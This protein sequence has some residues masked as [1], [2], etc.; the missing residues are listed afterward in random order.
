VGAITERSEWRQVQDELDCRRK[1][2]VCVTAPAVR[3]AVGEELGLGPG[4]VTTGQMVTAQRRLGEG[5]S[6]ALAAL[7][8]AHPVLRSP[9]IGLGCPL[10]SP[11]P[12]S[13]PHALSPTRL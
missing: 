1:V 10:L 11:H 3:V 9:V 7:G 13:H 8:P 4:S 12:P 6:G 5:A 2:M